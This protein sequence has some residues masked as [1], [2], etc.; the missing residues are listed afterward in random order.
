MHPARA[1][2]RQGVARAIVA[3]PRAL[4]RGFASSIRARKR[5]G[6]QDLGTAFAST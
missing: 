2:V 3:L 5:D 6:F 4:L 1:C